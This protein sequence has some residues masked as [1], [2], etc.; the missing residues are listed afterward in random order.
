MKLVEQHI[1][2]R[3]DPR[4][5]SIDA[6]AFAAKHLWNAANY[7]VR[8]A[9]IFQGVYLDNVEVFH[10]IKSH[11]A[12]E[13]LP[14]KVSNQVLIQLDTAWKA[15]FAAIEEWREHPEK[16]LG[17]PKLPK[18]KH[19]TEGRNLLVYEKGALSKRALKR[20]MVSLSGLGELVKTKQTR[21]TI[22][23]V[24]IIPRS[25]HY[26]IEVIYEQATRQATVDPQ[27]VAS[28]DLGVNNLAALTTNLRGFVPLLVNGRP[29]K[30]INQT[31]NQ[32]RAHLK[33]KLAKQ[34]RFA[35]KRLDRLTDKRNRRM[36]HYLHVASRRII[37]VLV[38]HGIGMLIIGLNPLWKQEVEI[39]RRNNQN[40][41]QI[42]HAR[43]V[44]MLRYKAQLVGISVVISE[45]S[46]TSKASFLDLDEIPTYDPTRCES[47]HF[48]GKRVARG[49]YR[50][51]D[52]RTL[53]ADINGSFNILRKVIPNAFS[54]GIEGTAVCPRRLAV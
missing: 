45:E 29:L 44:E 43:F 7:V 54:R 36:K 52:G 41:V 3:G 15:F 16:F 19:K 23:Q 33:S 6:A 14:R 11:E 18:Y 32:Q 51:A 42:P 31:Y 2:E 1:I 53:N 34:K 20:G 22:S 12:Y 13:G 35:S 50:A 10:Q 25:T 28:L 24:R 49:L 27:R 38:E 5:R 4:F 40:F 47:P 37:D 8:Q 17:C 39:G 21:E 48:S 26:V 9:F 46:Y 30:A